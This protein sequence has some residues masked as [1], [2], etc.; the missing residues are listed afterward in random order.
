MEAVKEASDTSTSPIEILD[1]DSLISIFKLLPVAERIK[2]ERVSRTWK[3]LAKQ[4][5]SNVTVLNM[6]PKILG[7]KPFGKK[8][9]YSE[10]N[11]HVLE[12][13]LIRCGKYLQK[14][15]LNS[16]H[17]CML[18]ILANYSPN[19]QS[20]ESDKAS[21][22]GIA[23]LAEN[24][25]NICELKT[26]FYRKMRIEKKFEKLFLS[27]QNFRVLDLN[28]WGIITG[29]C[30]LKLPLEEMDTIKLHIVQDEYDSEIIANVIRKTKK[31]RVF[32]VQFRSISLITALANSC[33][34]LSELFLINNIEDDSAN[35]DHLFSQVFKNNRN[36]K[37]LSLYYFDNFTAECFSYLNEN[38]IEEITLTGTENIQK[39]YLSKSLPSFKN[40]QA[41]TFASLEN[42]FDQIAECI[43]LCFNLKKLTLKD[44]NLSSEKKLIETISSLNNLELLS[45]GCSYHDDIVSYDFCQYISCN[46]LQLK[47][48][49][50]N[51]FNGIS[52]SGL[53][54]ICELP[55]LEMLSIIDC[56]S[57]SDAGL[58]T[59][60][61]ISKLEELNISG[62]ANITGSG[63]INLFNLKKLHCM[64]CNG[65]ED[66]GLINFL[67]YASNLEFLDIRFTNITNSVVDQAIDVTK[68][69]IN[70]VLLRMC[71][72]DTK[73]DVNEIEIMSPLLHLDRIF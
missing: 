38:V 46:L 52:D 18:S 49:K 34:N 68:N 25:R 72:R 14:I 21:V 50:I 37:S 35:M 4:S 71:I 42:N 54:L 45:V 59:V 11:D 67:N 30:F 13:I 24:C 44:C 23:Q 53:K 64:D 51:I 55:K 19:I 66:D 73:I 47:Y 36:L 17:E 62:C 16:V 63:L 9:D 48:L 65:L 61:K 15:N 5:W 32:K 29:K 10:I 8:H 26:I 41:L 27:N 22:E 31:L 57:I 28:T 69:R 56:E 12:Q 60:C 70:N 2:I 3:I 39:V 33:S 6:D 58:Q 1:D 7:L 43:E 20:I 40:L